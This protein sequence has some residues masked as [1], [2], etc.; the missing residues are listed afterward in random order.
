MEAGKGLVL[1]LG[2]L[3]LLVALYCQSDSGFEELLGRQLMRSSD[4][5]APVAIKVN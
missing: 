4:G 3:A 2:F 1:S 5:L